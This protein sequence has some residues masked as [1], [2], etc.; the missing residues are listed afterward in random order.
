[1]TDQEYQE[2]A[3]KHYLG[4]LAGRGN[5]APFSPDG[6][7][8]G[9]GRLME[10]VRAR[11]TSVALGPMKQ[12]YANAVRSLICQSPDTSDELF[13]CEGY[14]I[15]TEGLGLPIQHAWLVDGAGRVVDPTWEDASKHVY[16]GV[17]FRT[18]L[19]LEMLEEAGMV[20]GLLH[21]PDLMRRHF[22]TPQ[23]FAAALRDGDCDQA[24]AA[25][26]HVNQNPRL[27]DR[28]IN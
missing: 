14:A 20:P 1:M 27:E 17:T 7:L 16:F 13:Y 3:F 28:A 19:V 26:F 12:C 10:V 22:G 15:E 11:P 4:K 21:S 8:L 25:K 23:L 2:N 24:T 9:F 18:S 5:L 6:A